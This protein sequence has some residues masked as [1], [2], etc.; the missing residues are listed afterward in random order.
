MK[1][2]KIIYSQNTDKE[3]YVDFSKLKGFAYDVNTKEFVFD[4]AQPL[5]IEN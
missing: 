1:F 3:V 2:I 4:D 5:K